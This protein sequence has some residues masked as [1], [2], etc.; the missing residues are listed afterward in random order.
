[1]HRQDHPSPT[2]NGPP[3][4]PQASLL[5]LA[6]TPDRVR[7]LGTI[8]ADLGPSLVAAPSPE[9]ALRRLRRGDFAV[10]LLDV[11]RPG[12]EGLETARRIRGQEQS[13]NTPIIFLAD[14]APLGFSVVEA[15]RL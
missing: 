5:L 15:Y 13:R 9:E 1:M 7:L 10:I 14:P 6:D 3:P 11:S 4:V 8:L 12:R 2:S